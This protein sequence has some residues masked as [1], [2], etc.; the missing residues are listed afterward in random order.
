[1]NCI[2]NL[3]TLR[4]SIAIFAAQVMIVSDRFG[5]SIF[6]LSLE[7]ENTML[8]TKAGLRD[9]FMLRNKLPSNRT[10]TGMTAFNLLKNMRVWTFFIFALICICL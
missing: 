6:L 8:R 9:S 2:S 7:I 3:I 1:M 10:D 5:A 4:V